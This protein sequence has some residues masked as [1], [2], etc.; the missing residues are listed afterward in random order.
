MVW[1]EGA[2]VVVVLVW[3]L[4]NVMVVIGRLDRGVSI[5]G[6]G[7]GEKGVGAG[8]SCSSCCGMMVARC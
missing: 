8:I 1:K 4:V 3:K 7:Y 6:I 5:G 2:V